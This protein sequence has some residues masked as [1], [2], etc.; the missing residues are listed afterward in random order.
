MNRILEY[1]DCL[2][3]EAKCELNFSKDYEFLIAVMLSAQTTDKRVNKVT[4]VLFKKYDSLEKLSQAN[5]TDICE[6]IKELGNYTKKS[7]AIIEI[8]KR[9][10]NECNGVV[11]NK[12]SY[13]ETLPMVGRKTTSVVLSNLY[14]IPNIAVDT[15]VSRVSKRLGLVRE[16]DD[17]VIIERK[18]KRIFPKEKWIKLHHQLVLFGR[19]KCKSIKPECNNCGLK[20]ICRYEKRNII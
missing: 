12:R 1:L 7:Q 11:P 20:E 10:L 9:I 5:I 3:K 13:L 17:V 14:N 2:Y 6:I 4:E 8:S 19:Y 15:H 18:L 16:K